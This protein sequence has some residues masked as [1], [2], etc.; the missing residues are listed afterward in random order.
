MK[1]SL[2]TLAIHKHVL[3]FKSID[4]VILMIHVTNIN[5]FMFFSPSCTPLPPLGMLSGLWW[6]YSINGHESC[7][8]KCWWL[9]CDDCCT[10]FGFTYL[11]IHLPQIASSPKANQSPKDSG[12]HS[13][14]NNI[15]YYASTENSRSDVRRSSRCSRGSINED[16]LRVPKRKQSRTNSLSNKD[17]DFELQPRT[18]N[19]EITVAG[20]TVTSVSDE[21]ADE[22]NT[23]VGIEDY[24]T[25]KR[26]FLPPLDA[27][28]GGA[29]KEVQQPTVLPP[30]SNANGWTYSTTYSQ[31]INQSQ[32]DTNLKTNVN[33]PSE[34]ALLTFDNSC[35]S[36]TPLV[37]SPTTEP[38]P[39]ILSSEPSPS[40]P[41]GYHPHVAKKS[42]TPEEPIQE[43]ITN[44]GDPDRPT[45][46]EE[47]TG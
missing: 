42:L 34:N 27:A 8:D 25:P 47:V 5:H 37:I 11:P 6:I 39:Q 28:N 10:L 38:N 26:T 40:A 23:K 20:V 4:I 33:T 30:I 17:G 19:T 43:D 32:S 45:G 46:T 22:A 1:I 3:P 36:T 12:F 31:P 16:S 29:P 9:I 18:Q 7:A 24:P 21:P 2:F 15:F 35:N 14:D 41:Q 13:H 44:K